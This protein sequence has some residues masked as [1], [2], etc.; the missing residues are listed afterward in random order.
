MIDYTHFTAAKA[1]FERNPGLC[2][3]F[4]F[5]AIESWKRIEFTYSMPLIKIYETTLTQNIAFTIN[6]YKSVY[7]GINIDLYESENERANGND[8]EMILSFPDFDWD[9]YAPIQAKKIYRNGKYD[10]IDHGDQIIDLIIYARSEGRNGYPLY[11]LYNYIDPIPTKINPSNELYGCSIVDAIYLRD[12]YYN[13]RISVRKGVSTL[14]WKIPLFGDLHPRHAIP[15]HQLVC[16]TT[17]AL[18]VKRLLQIT[19]TNRRIGIMADHFLN[20]DV[21][22]DWAE[23]PGFIR[24]N[25]ISFSGWVKPEF[26]SK[27]INNDFDKTISERSVEGKETGFNPKYRMVL[28]LASGEMQ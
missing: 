24:K 13:K 27:Q 28:T 17:P 3:L 1:H 14:K 23:I 11:L 2:N 19:T 7:P 6:A 10:A 18:M 8:L 22:T 16:D 25:S 26:K 20:K 12:H 21:I 15:W 5:L 4:K 9:F